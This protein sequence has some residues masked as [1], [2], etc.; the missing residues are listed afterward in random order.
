MQTS[1]CGLALQAIQASLGAGL[2]VPAFRPRNV[3]YHLSDHL[4]DHPFV[5]RKTWLS[6]FAMISFGPTSSPG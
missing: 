1:T 6:A 5:T 4:L 3:R 2:L